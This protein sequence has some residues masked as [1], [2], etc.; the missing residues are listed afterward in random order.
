MYTVKI[1]LTNYTVYLVISCLIAASSAFNKLT[2]LY[3]WSQLDY[4]FASDEH[5]RYAIERGE[6]VPENNLPVGIEVWKNKLFVTV[7]R[8]RN[9]NI[10]IFYK[11]IAESILINFND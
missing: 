6:F 3:R 10:K 11:T 4:S 1:V 9:G 7:P 2:E 8:W 5:R